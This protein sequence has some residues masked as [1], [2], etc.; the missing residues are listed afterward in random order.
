[1]LDFGYLAKWAHIG[2]IALVIVG[3]LVWG[4]IGV[5]G[6]NIVASIFGKR[7]PAYT[8]YTL[9][10]LAA[11][12]L[13]FSRDTYLPFLGET[14]L[15]CSLLAEQTPEHADTEVTV[16]QL[17]PGAKV[18]FWAAEPR[19]DGLGR[20]NDW[21]K[22]YLKFANA[23]VTTADEAGRAVLRFRNPQAYSVPFK[24]NLPAHV[25]WRVCKEGGMIGPVQTIP[26]HGG[27]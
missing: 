3:G 27:F 22:A 24:G 15:P 20:I 12:L 2:V 9:V 6:P 26:I 19:T 16:S 13:V 7:W 14:V 4:V 8:I 5:G 17:H 11:L 18:L 10:G 1:M 23:G 21:R 25:H